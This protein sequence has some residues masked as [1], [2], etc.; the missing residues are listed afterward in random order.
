M[1]RPLL[2]LLGAVAIFVVAWALFVPP[3]QVPDEQAHFGYVQ[4]LVEDG[5]RPKGGGRN[6]E[7]HLSREE[8]LAIYHS[9]ALT[10]IQNPAQKP[11]WS[12]DADARWRRAA[13]ELRGAGR[14]HISNLGTQAVNPPL[15]YLYEAIPYEVASGGDFFDRLYAMRLFSGLLLLLTAVTGWLL[16]GELFGRAPLLQLAG[17]SVVGLQ[18]MTTFISGGV[19]PDALFN[20]LIGLVLWLSV[21]TLVRG[22]EWRRA[23]ALAAAMLA[24]VLV[25][26]TALLFLPAVAFALLVPVWRERTRAQRSVLVRRAAAV[27]GGCAVV[28]AV[29]LSAA[30]GGAGQVD[31]AVPQS[32]AMFR[33]FVAYLLNFYLPFKPPLVRDFPVLRTF[34][35]YSVWIKTSWASFGWLETKFPD[36][37]YPLFALIT[38]GAFGG[39]LLAIR[40]RTARIPWVVVGFFLLMLIP[41]VLGLHWLEYREQIT[42]KYGIRI[43]G[44]YLLPL[45]P[46]AGVAV[47][48]SLTLLRRARRNVAAGLVVGG[49]AVLQLCS[50]AIVAGRFYE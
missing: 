24:A 39:G 34:S 8:E 50:L 1:P 47:A 29:A 16:V 9:R 43:Q 18:P 35:P 45:M 26:G 46:I 14:G 37:V 19:N 5:K 48:A 21:R 20:P 25:K 49:M 22:L 15:Y 10:I 40:R 38:L 30:R 17:A 41:L 3:L 27:L 33:E 11:P 6:A 28:A 23:V 4:S 44:R 36:A 12:D 7:R 32:F 31:Y 13:R 2:L 42:L